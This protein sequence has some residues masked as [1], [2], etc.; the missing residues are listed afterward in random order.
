MSNRIEV[1]ANDVLP[2]S[3][4]IKT[5]TRQFYNILQLGSQFTQ[6]IWSLGYG[7]GT[8][9]RLKEKQYFHLEY[10]ASHVNEGVFWTKELNLLSQFKFNF[11]WQLQGKKS[12]FLGP[13][14]NLLASKRTN[15]ETMEVIGSALPNYTILDST[16]GT[17]N[18]KMWFG[19]NGGFRF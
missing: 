8:T 6:D 9:F 5:G 4:G 17:T 2:A 14:W 11:D 18:W 7:I 1:G 12:L 13:S 15:A 19:V 3:V 10:V 16:R